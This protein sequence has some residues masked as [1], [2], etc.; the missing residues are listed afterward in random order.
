MRQLKISKQITGRESFSI[1]KYLQEIGKIEMLAPDEEA[2]LA[3]RIRSGDKEAREVLVMSNLRFVVSVAKQYQNH[4]LALDDLINEGNLGLIKAAECFDETKG[5]KFIS[6]AVWWIRQSILQAIAENARLVRLPLNK[7]SSINKV[8]RYFFRLEQ[9]FQ[10]EPTVEEIA[11]QMDIAPE[12]VRESFKI[13][14]R[15]V[16]MDA[17][18]SSEGDA[19][20]MYDVFVPGD[21]VIP[22]A[23]QKLNADSLKTEIDRSLAIL[24]DRDALIIR[25]YYGLGGFQAMSLEEIGSHLGLTSERVRQIKS[26]AIK[27]LK[28]TCRNKR[29][30]TYL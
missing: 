24:Q 23:E 21:N 30:K 9:E 25:M 2:M 17:P 7:I 4:G 22:E 10:R 5:F 20:T 16:S 8:N 13:S 27:R 12:E 15:P 14:G 1:E 11:A 26:K 29:L 3:K 19:V 6:Y 18:L 28:T